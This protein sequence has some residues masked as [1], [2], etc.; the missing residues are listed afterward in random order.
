MQS[1]GL[2]NQNDNSADKRLSE[3]DLFDKYSNDSVRN[4]NFEIAYDNKS[5]APNY[6][7]FKAT[8]LNTGLTKEICCE[9]PFLSGAIHRE[10]N[11]DYD[12]KGT[13][14]VDSIIKANSN[15]TFEFK[16]QEALKNIS[17]NEYPDYDRLLQIA[18]GIDLDNYYKTYGAND[19]SKLMYF[20]S[21]TGFVQITFTHIMFKCGILTRR[22]CEAGNNIWFGN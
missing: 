19:S 20:E 5:T 22:D 11:V 7:V 21:D 15:R 3:I 12:T 13:E 17:F 10:L 18:K 4:V 1:C 8:D 16:N 6:L 14:F 2:R 9:A